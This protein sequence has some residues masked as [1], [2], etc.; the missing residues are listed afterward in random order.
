MLPFD[1]KGFLTPD[2]NLPSTLEEF[3][4]EFVSKFPLQVKRQ[5]LF[6]K[7]L[8]FLLDFF[9]A[10]GVEEIKH[11]GL[12]CFQER[13]RTGKDIQIKRALLN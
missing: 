6:N 8:R 9:E 13:E 2:K 7:F 3:Q 12:N 10:I 1:S 11:T 4:E 5:E